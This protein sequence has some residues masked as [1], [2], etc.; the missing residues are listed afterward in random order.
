MY[1]KKVETFVSILGLFNFGS[2]VSKNVI[3]NVF[4]TTVINRI[5]DQTIYWKNKFHTKFA[6]ENSYKFTQKI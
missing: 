6:Q 3:E 4:H 2:H 5:L 1:K